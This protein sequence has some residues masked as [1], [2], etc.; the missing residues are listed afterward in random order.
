MRRAGIVAVALPGLVLAVLGLFHP[1]ALTPSTA[2]VWWQF[3]VVALPLFPLLAVALW[4]LLRGEDGMLAWL[5]RV[6]GYVYAVF[7]TALDLLVGVAAG[8]VVERV[9]GGSQEALDLRALGNDLGLIGSAGFLVAAALTVAI[10]VR[11][12]WRRAL[13]G[14]AL[15]VVAAV[16]FLHGHIYWPTGGLAMVGV[17]DRA[18]SCRRGLTSAVDRSV[19]RPPAG[20]RPDR[21]PSLPHRGRRG[22]VRR[23]MGARPGRSEGVQ[24]SRGGA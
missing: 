2:T 18:V 23:R 16:P 9:Q 24:G 5:A 6:A 20:R 19:D 3:H 4:V 15:L 22:G 11:R 8:V 12:D 17:G 13:P 1:G 21:D 10:L 14:G 7:Y